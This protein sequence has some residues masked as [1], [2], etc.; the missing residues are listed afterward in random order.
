MAIVINQDILRGKPVIAGT[1]IS[2]ELIL[3]LLS[4]GMSVE[5]IVKEYPHLTR[6]NVLEAIEYAKKSLEHEEV[7]SFSSPAA[8]Q[9]A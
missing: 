2:V 7:V 9:V 5:E 3:E 6:K 4:S 1:R 8:A